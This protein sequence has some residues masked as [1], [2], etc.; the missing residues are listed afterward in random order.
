MLFTIGKV[1]DYSMWEVYAS[2]KTKMHLSLEG[3]EQENCG[4]I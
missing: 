4:R 1:F 2:Q 3:I